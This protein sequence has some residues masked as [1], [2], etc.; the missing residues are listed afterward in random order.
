MLNIV[1]QG[2]TDSQ[3]T[4]NFTIAANLGSTFVAGTT[5]TTCHSAPAYVPI[6]EGMLESSHKVQLQ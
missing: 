5:C 4:F 6:Q 2:I 1:D 3:Q